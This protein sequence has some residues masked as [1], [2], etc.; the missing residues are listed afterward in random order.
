MTN[1]LERIKKC[2][3]Q[4]SDIVQMKSE[5]FAIHLSDLAKQVKDLFSVIDAAKENDELLMRIDSCKVPSD[6]EI[7]TASYENVDTKFTIICLTPYIAIDNEGQLCRITSRDC[8]EYSVVT[9]PIKDVVKDIASSSDRLM[10]FHWNMVILREY[11]NTVYAKI[12]MMIDAIDAQY[13]E[14]APYINSIEMCLSEFN[15]YN[16]S[17]LNSFNKNI[18]LKKDET[19]VASFEDNIDD[20]P[21]ESSIDDKADEVSSGDTEAIA[22]T[23]EIPDK[24]KLDIPIEHIP[25]FKNERLKSYYEI[26]FPIF[27]SNDETIISSFM[28]SARHCIKGDG[29]NVVV[30]LYSKSKYTLYSSIGEKV[31]MDGYELYKYYKRCRYVSK[32]SKA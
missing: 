31:S 8:P 12:D 22:E 21:C 27:A 5:V 11:I 26:K 18:E 7:M 10:Q 24:L 14:I 32:L 20:L 16:M 6:L 23:D 4:Q 28:I 9:V 3:K 13:N 30:S 2:N 25:D 1:R 17:P 29:D 15:I 19:P